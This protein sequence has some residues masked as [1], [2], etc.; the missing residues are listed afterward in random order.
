MVIFQ[1]FCLQKNINLIIMQRARNVK[2]GPNIPEG[3][4]KRCFIACVLISP[5][6]Y[7]EVCL[8]RKM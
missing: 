3:F 6:N 1:D 5:N 8:T 2:L 4:Q 7:A